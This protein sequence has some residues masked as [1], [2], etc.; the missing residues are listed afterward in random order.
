MDK[1]KVEVVYALPQ[2]QRLI[3]VQVA[4]GCTALEAVQQSGIAK[5]FPDLDLDKAELGIYGKA[6]AKTQVLR[7]GDRVEIY[8]PLIIDPK[9][10]RKARAAKAKAAKG[11]DVEVGEDDE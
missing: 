10:A 3:A 7:E 2:V 8:R 6:V 4:P 1:I 5:A 11:G 9:E